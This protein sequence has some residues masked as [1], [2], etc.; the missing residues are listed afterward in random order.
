MLDQRTGHVA[1]H[2]LAMA[3]VSVEFATGFTMTHGSDSW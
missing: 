1:E 3:A 2:R